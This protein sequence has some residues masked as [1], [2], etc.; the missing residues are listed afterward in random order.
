MRINVAVPEA[1]VTKPV[2]D[3]ALESV[4][5]LNEQLIKNGSVPTFHKA[6][7]RDNILWKPEPPGDEHFDHAGVVQRRRWGD[8]DDLA[9]WQA[10]SLRATGEDPEAVAV[11]RRS[12]PTRWHAYV[13]RSDGTTEDPSRE[14][15]MGKKAEGVVGAA[16]PLMYLPHESESIGGDDLGETIV[17]PSIAFRE[18]PRDQ[19]QARVDLPWHVH[20]QRIILPTEYGMATLQSNPNP[21]KALVGALEGAAKLGLAAGYAH[22]EHIKRMMAIADAVEGIPY[23]EIAAC[24]GDDHAQAAHQFVVG[25]L[26]GKIKK[27]AKGAYKIAKKGVKAVNRVVPLSRLVKFIPGVEPL[28]EEAISFAMTHNMGLGPKTVLKL[29]KHIG[30]GGFPVL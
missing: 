16:L 27:A 1:Q 11:V 21:V 13:E 17:R 23:E 30:P 22:P 3:A 7:R 12:G 28:A 4:T 26:W 18:L 9:P 2:L 8:C 5:R 15:G 20:T 29:A 14:A 6:L 25:S 19:L 24:Y 10:A